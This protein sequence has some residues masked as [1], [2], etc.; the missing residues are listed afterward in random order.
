[1]AN[2]ERDRTV[3]V[4]TRPHRAGTLPAD[5]FRILLEMTDQGAD[6]LFQLL[7]LDDHVDHPMVEQKLRPLELVRQLLLDRLLN[8]ARAG[9]SGSA[10]W[11][12]Q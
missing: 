3:L 10:L 8:D 6:R 11:A 4:P 9:E 2:T 7:A 1:M 5:C 12:R